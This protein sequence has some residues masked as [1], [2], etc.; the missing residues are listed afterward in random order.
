MKF[1]ETELLNLCNT[2][3]RKLLFQVNLTHDGTKSLRCDGPVFWNNFSRNIND[4]I[5]SIM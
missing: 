1:T 5:S 3:D 4:N 2:R